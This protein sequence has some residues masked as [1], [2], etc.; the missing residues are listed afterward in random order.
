MSYL[1]HFRY[2]VNVCEYALKQRN[3]IKA[4][5]YS[6]KAS[7]F[8]Q[9]CQT[10]DAPANCLPENFCFFLITFLGLG[11]YISWIQVLFLPD[12]CDKS[13]QKLQRK[14]IQRSVLYPFACRFSTSFAP[15]I[16]FRSLLPL[17]ANTVFYLYYHH[18]QHKMKTKNRGKDGF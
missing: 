17:T 7:R 1:I 12:K 9:I 5:C 13:K 14:K 16:I 18:D 8:S 15:V 4:W 3:V 10:F 6:K 2:L 11:F